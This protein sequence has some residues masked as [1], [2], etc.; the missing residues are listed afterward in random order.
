M[1][2][3]IKKHRIVMTLAAILVAAA[4]SPA[5]PANGV[6]VSHLY[7]LANFSGTIPYNEATISADRFHDEVYVLYQNYVRVYNSSGMEVYGFG[8]DEALGWM[9][10]LAV[11]E[12]GDIYLLSYGGYSVGSDRPDYRMVR[13]NYRGEALESITVKDLPP[14]YSRFLPQ[15]LIYRDGRFILV[16][17]NQ[18]LAVETDKKGVFRR[19]YDFGRL[20]EIP[21]KDRPN[22]DIFGFSVDGQGNMLFT[23]PVLFQAFRVSPDGNVS[24][25]GRGGSSPGSFGVV[26]GIVADDHGNYL[27]ADSQRSVVMVFDP[28]F[29]FLI[30]FGYYGNKPQNLVRPRNIA[31]GNSGRLYVVQLGHRGVSVFSVTPN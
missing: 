21:E 31:I 9:R 2:H 4:A 7:K 14:E 27:V 10:D 8:N 12:K 23:I 15:R 11:D 16:S 26:S 22:T 5:F 3:A 13:C 20:L 24:S 6:D 1:N 28:T 25:F 17:R 19:G 18:P 29:K 30:E